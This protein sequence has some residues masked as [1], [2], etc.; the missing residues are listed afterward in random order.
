MRSSRKLPFNESLEGALDAS[1]QGQ[2][3]L[4][5]P[6]ITD[7]NAIGVTLYHAYL[8]YDV[9]NNFYMA[10]NPVTLKLVK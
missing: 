8:V 2:A 5:V 6:K 7:Q 4:V 10:S 1:G 3:S 9:S